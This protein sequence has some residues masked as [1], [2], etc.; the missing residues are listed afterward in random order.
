MGQGLLCDSETRTWK[1]ALVMPAP[2]RRLIF[3]FVSTTTNERRLERTRPRLIRS[4]L[5]TS[6]W[7]Q[8][9]IELKSLRRTCIYTIICLL[10]LSTFANCRSQFLNCRSQFLLD[11]LGICLTDRILPRYILSR[12]CVSVRPRIFSYAKKPQTRLARKLFISS[13][14]WIRSAAR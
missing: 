6:I 9:A 12:V 14:V 5:P 1:R 7:N 2:T 11:R 8:S 10:S 4:T 3:L 13:G